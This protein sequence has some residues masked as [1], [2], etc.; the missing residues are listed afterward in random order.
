[1]LGVGSSEYFQKLKPAG[2]EATSKKNLL[3][4][5]GSMGLTFKRTF[6]FGF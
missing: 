4:V 6:D 1:M 5:L 3:I 2:S